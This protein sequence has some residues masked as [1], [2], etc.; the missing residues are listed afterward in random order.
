MIEIEYETSV[1]RQFLGHRN[2]LFNLFCTETSKVPQLHEL[3]KYIKKNGIHN[4][5]N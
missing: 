3:F 4:V 1:Q 5:K 2:C